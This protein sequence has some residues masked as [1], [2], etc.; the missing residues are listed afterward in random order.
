MIKMITILFMEIIIQTS[1]LIVKKRL[2]KIPFTHNFPVLHNLNLNDFIAV[3]LKH[4]ENIK[5]KN[6]NRFGTDIIN[7]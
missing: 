4:D 6:A 7:D 1:A 5:K 2:G 3:S